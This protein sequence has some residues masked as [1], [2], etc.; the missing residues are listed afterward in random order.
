MACCWVH[1]RDEVSNLTIR[2]E[3]QIFNINDK[4][5]DKK[6]EW[7]YHIQRMDPYRIAR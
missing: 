4:I 2:S 7:H 1:R 6:T 5:K 3:L